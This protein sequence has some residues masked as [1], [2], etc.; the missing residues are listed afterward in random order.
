MAKE[1]WATITV[2][3]INELKAVLL[4]LACVYIHVC[5]EDHTCR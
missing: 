3:L 2:V 5:E 4:S 1:I